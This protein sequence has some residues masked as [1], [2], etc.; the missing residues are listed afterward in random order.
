MVFM[1]DYKMCQFTSLNIS[2]LSSHTKLIPNLNL[3]FL[4]NNENLFVNSY[5]H[6]CIY[7]RAMSLEKY[8]K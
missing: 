1:K 7:L 6:L 8:A 3:L 5:F 2:L 4:V